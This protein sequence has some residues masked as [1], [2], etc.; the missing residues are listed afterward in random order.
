MDRDGL[1]GVV[2]YTIAVLALVTPPAALMRALDV[3]VASAA[4]AAFILLAMWAPAVARLIATRTVDRGWRPVFPIRRWGEPRGWVLL[5]PL[6]T[7][8]GTYSVAYTIALIWGIERSA[9]LWRGPRDIAIN[10]AINLPLLAGL[11]LAGAI[12][13][14]LGWR[15]YLQPR[16]DQLRVRG[17][18]LIVVVVELVYH[19]PII[20]L[21]GYLGSGSITRT[22]GLAFVGKLASSAIWTHGTYRLRSI[23][24]AFWFHSLHNAFSQTIFPKIFGAGPD[25][26]LGELG[27][28]PVACSLAVALALLVFARVQGRPFFERA[29]SVGRDGDDA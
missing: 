27:I 19:L 29:W 20:V 23:W 3:K 4:G 2:V 10:V 24:V 28:L 22:L 26:V 15:G 18:L 1:R 25:D 5:V 6:L 8:L 21:A 9:P 14:E 12:G 13:E 16:L 7:V 17:S 11:G